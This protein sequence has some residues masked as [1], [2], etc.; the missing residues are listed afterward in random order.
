MPSSDSGE[1]RRS[2]QPQNR[3]GPGAPGPEKEN[4]PCPRCDSTNTKFCYYNNYNYSQPRHFCK[5]CRRYWTQG[6]TLRDI[7]VGGGTRKNAKR[8]R[9][10]HNAVTSSSSCSVV[11][12]APEHHHQYQSMTPISAVHGGTMPFC[13]SSVVEGD[14]KQ[15]MSVSGSFTSLLNNSNTQQGNSGGLLALGGFGLGLGQGLDE[16]GFGIGGGRTGWGF[17][18]MVDGSNIGG[19]PVVSSNLWQLEG[20]EGGFVGGGDHYFSWPGLAISTPVNG[21][22]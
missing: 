18:G 19:V 20:G 6:G 13:G 8:S 21:L 7:P 2:T 3:P 14:G 1:S 11:S 17:P 5:G 9:T 22:K 15:N 4:L 10:Q 12:S 16:M